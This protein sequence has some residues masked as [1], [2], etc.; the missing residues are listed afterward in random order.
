MA[1]KPISEEDA[2]RHAEHKR[3][4]KREKD[5]RYRERHLDKIR[6]KDR[7]RSLDARTN[8][9]K[10]PKRLASVRKY[11]AAH[12]EEARADYWENR[13][14]ICAD[15]RA[16]RASDPEKFREH[17]RR[18]KRVLSPEQRDRANAN[19][20]RRW[21]ESPD[22]NATKRAKTVIWRIT[23]KERDAT[24]DRIYRINNADKVSVWRLISK[25]RKLHRK[26]YAAA[27]EKHRADAR[28]WYANNKDSAKASAANSRAKRALAPGKWTAADI[29]N[30]FAL[31]RGHCAMCRIS[32]RKS[33]H[34]DH[35]VPISKG[36]TNWP[37]NLQLLCAP[38]NLKKSSKDPIEFAQEIGKLL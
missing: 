19:A 11:N 8:P 22:D 26:W 37:R 3:A 33:Y 32:I 38:C 28:R 14:A 16:Q 29:R 1:K 35:I 2:A 13:D 12:A 21:A 7:A 27:P 6:A 25:G 5:R 30:I 4:Q 24:R 36:G 15:R 31:Q 9:A 34:I 23:N 10:R 18:R 17:D 20:R